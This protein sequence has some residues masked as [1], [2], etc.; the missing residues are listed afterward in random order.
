MFC[1]PRWGPSILRK[2]GKFHHYFRNAQ[3]VRMHFKIFFSAYKPPSWH[4]FPYSPQDCPQRNLRSCRKLA[5]KGHSGFVQWA[6]HCGWKARL[7]CGSIYCPQEQSVRMRLQCHLYF[8]KILFRSLVI[9]YLL[10]T[11]SSAPHQRF[12][13][14]ISRH[15]SQLTLSC[16][17]VVGIS[18][19]LLNGVSVNSSVKI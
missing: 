9:F 1:I 4:P 18:S 19:Q 12:P 2:L 15:Y 6:A 16:C 11:R 3:P 14:P 8:F 10:R 13:A 7:Q 17:E 5:L